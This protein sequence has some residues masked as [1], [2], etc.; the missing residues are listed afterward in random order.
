MAAMVE[1]IALPCADA[2]EATEAQLTTVSALVEDADDMA[3]LTNQC[4]LVGVRDERSQTMRLLFEEL[5]I[6]LQQGFISLKRQAEDAA[7]SADVKPFIE[8]LMAIAN[9]QRI[10]CECLHY[11]RMDMRRFE[12]NQAN[13]RVII[14]IQACTSPA[15]LP[16]SLDQGLFHRARI[17]VC[18]RLSDLRRY[19]CSVSIP[20]FLACSHTWIGILSICS[21]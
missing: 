4:R 19:Y 9:G 13:V 20:F 5:V 6:G 11:N 7:E 1:L 2:I 10:S 3:Y 21:S 15:R 12:L 14:S 16:G 17:Q 18:S 8:A